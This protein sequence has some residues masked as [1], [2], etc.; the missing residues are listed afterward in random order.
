MPDSAPQALLV[1]CE[2]KLI[3]CPYFTRA[4]RNGDSNPEGESADYMLHGHQN[5]DRLE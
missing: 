2:V 5:Y 4:A 3:Y 1:G